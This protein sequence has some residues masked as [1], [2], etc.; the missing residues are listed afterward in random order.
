VLVGHQVNITDITGVAPSSGE[1]VVVRAR[2]DG[3][4]RV[5]SMLP[6]P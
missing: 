1:G 6:A 5:V 2:A 3:V 4:L